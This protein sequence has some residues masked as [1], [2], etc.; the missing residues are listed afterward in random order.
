MATM[1]GLLTFVSARGNAAAHRD[2]V[3]DALERIQHR[4]PDDS[5]LVA[6][7]DVVFG[8]HRLAVTDLVRGR[9]PL[10]YPPDGVTAGRYLIVFDGAIYNAAELR[11]EMIN[12][13]GTSFATE[14][15][16]EVVVAAYH[17]W[18]PS[19]VNRLRGMFAFVIWDGSARRAFGARDP[20][21]IK[22]LYRLATPG[23]VYFA[24][25]KKALLTF[26]DDAALD[27]DNL[28]HY[29]TLQY[30]PEPGTMHRGIAR[31][32]A[33]E[34]FVYTP[35]G[36]VANRRYSQLTFSPAPVDD[37]E[38]VVA[39][40]QDALRDSVH[41]HLR[42]DVPVGAFLSSGLD[43]TAIVALAREV[44]P[45]IPTYSVG[46]DVEGFSEIEVAERTAREM[47][48][49]ITSTLVTADD[50]M[51]VLPR[52]VWHLD[53]PV[54]DPAVVPLYF[55]AEAASR[56]VTVVL[57]GDGADEL[58]GGY[59]IYREPLS[60]SAVSHLPDPMQRGLRAVSRVIPQGVK[61]KSFLERGTTPIEER[62]YGNARV[63]TEEDKAR[64]LCHYN[65]DVRHTDVTGPVFAEASSLDD[66]ATMQYIDL[67]T[68]L[69]GDILVKADRM[70]MAHS[71]QLRTPFLD[72][73]VFEVAAT[74]PT[75]LKVPARTAETKVA[76][77]RAVAGL[78]PEQ[79]AQGRK[80]LFPTPILPWL[81]DEM[82]DWAHDVL[83]RSGAGD[84]LDLNLVRGLLN[85]HRKKEVDHARK[86]WTV[87][88]FCLWHAV[89]VAGTVRPDIPALAR[90][91]RENSTG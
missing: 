42:A 23:G 13:R 38:A 15:D 50:L 47:G 55:L 70:S 30:V 86:I 43:S 58:F 41:A 56:D 35:G 81:R 16:A 29:V 77:R 49:P 80:R 7:A 26:V 73:A 36:P 32:G 79:V 4:G 91:A 89:F 69:R 17:A 19:A 5:S 34:S 28:Q 61:G 25:E 82:H 10:S 39:R 2:A 60:L 37:E 90:P 53:D 45:R 8:A 75:E 14:S 64:L 62:Y 3:A 78:V 18:G 88:M 68:W 67:Y 1:A 84:L 57:S 51:R 63:F 74:L 22:P 20:Y 71:V 11:A 54:A 33:G 12:E 83:D 87:L 31:L 48:V 40:I 27:T 6:T 44:E 24:S 21:G 46:F 76:L 85:E 52:I 66:V 59:P 72:R 65:P 9:Q